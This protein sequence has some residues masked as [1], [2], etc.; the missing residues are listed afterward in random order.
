E[1][2]YAAVD[3]S[4][5]VPLAGPTP[6][7]REALTE[8]LRDEAKRAGMSVSAFQHPFHVNSTWL[9][10]R[11]APGDT[12]EANGLGRVVQRGRPLPSRTTGTDDYKICSC[13]HKCGYRTFHA[14]KVGRGTSRCAGRGQGVPATFHGRFTGGALI[15]GNIAASHRVPG[16]VRASHGAGRGPIL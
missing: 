6:G 3:Q 10:G 14:G 9:L 11:A 15:P 5:T 2:C 8:V 4:T 12:A 16:L 7:S 1:E 13:E